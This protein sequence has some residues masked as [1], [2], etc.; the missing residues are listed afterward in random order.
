MT[1]LILVLVAT[2]TIAL[3]VSVLA[4]DD[5][6]GSGDG[7]GTY[8]GSRPGPDVRYDGGPV[9]GAAVSSMTVRR[10]R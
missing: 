7:F 10:R 4:F 2:L 8:S 1:N 3:A 9:E 5:G 6:A